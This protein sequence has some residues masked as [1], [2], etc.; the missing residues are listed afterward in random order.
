M[1]SFPN[2]KINLGLEIKRKRSDG[3]HDIE[4]VMYPIGLCD[5]LEVLESPGII[6]TLKCTGLSIDPGSDEPGK[7]LHPQIGSKNL[8]MKVH[9][10]L[11]RDFSLPPVYIHLHKAIPAGAGLGGG[12]ADCAF[13]L[14]ML[15][16]LFNLGLSDEQQIYYVT[17]LGSDCAFFLNNLAAL[18]SGRGEILQPLYLSLQGYYIHLV[19]PGIQINTA[20]A[21]SWV[22]PSKRED[23][24]MQ[25]IKQPVKE[26]KD[27]LV[28]DFEIPVFER[29][30]ELENIKEQFYKSGA[31]YASMS[32]SGS[33]IF[34][35]FDKV[36]GNID[37]P[38]NYFQ[39]KSVLR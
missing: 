7:S 11:N 22:K 10:L 14:K 9:G 38:E 2:A 8:V 3:Y 27:N 35:L 28:N 21:Y 15:N 39:W 13:A 12:S 31:I 18:A 6:T 30:P 25:V 29:Y 33:A 37:F 32:G 4:T 16:K 1:I 34:G 24:L 36:P 26:W 19:K 5:V 23:S 20:E 17:Q